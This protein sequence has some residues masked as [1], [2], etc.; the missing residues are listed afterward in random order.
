M[1]AYLISALNLV[2]ALGIMGCGGSSTDQASG[3]G[4]ADKTM[5]VGVDNAKDAGEPIQWAQVRGQIVNAEGEGLYDK[6]VL[7]CSH[8]ICYS[9]ST[10]EDGRYEI[11]DIDPDDVYKMQ[12]ADP[13]RTYSSIYFYQETAAGQMSQL[14]APIIL[15]RRQFEL[16]SLPVAEGGVVSLAGGEITLTVDMAS[17]K[18]PVGLEEMLMADRVLGSSLPPYRNTP[19]SGDGSRLIAYTFNPSPITSESP[20]HFEV[21]YPEVGPPGSRFN[22]FSVNVETAAMDAV[23]SAT[24]GMDGILRGD[25]GGTLQ[26]L[27]TL[28][29]EPVE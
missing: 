7:C 17:I 21:N 23:G 29:F 28:V 14:S 11:I 24:V 18:Y 6:R 16:M 10:D 4:G 9:A 20:I 3:D 25:E 22:V 27:A 13:T 5:D 26:H 2:I 1:N 19:W 8:T 12:V 15:P